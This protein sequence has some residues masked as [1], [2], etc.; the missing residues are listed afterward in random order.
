[1]ARARLLAGAAGLA[2]P[3]HRVGEG[4][5][6][7]IRAHHP[8]TTDLGVYERSPVSA[9]S[10]SEESKGLRRFRA[11][12]TVGLVGGI[13]GLVIPVAANLLA[14]LDPTTGL[15]T[16]SLLGEITALLVVAGTILLAISFIFY[17]YGF[18]ALREFDRWFLAASVLCNIG[19]L[20][21]VLI[22]ISVALAVLSGPDLVQCIQGAPSH[23]L[24]CLDA[25]QPFAGPAVVAG[26]WLA[27]VGGLGIVVGLALGARRYEDMRLVGGAATYGVLL[28][29]LIDP[30]VALLFPI[31]GWQYP[32]LTIP[33]LALIAPIYVYAGSHRSLG[34]PIPGA[35]MPLR[36]A[37]AS[38]REVGSAP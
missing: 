4:T 5:G 35:T 12:A 22:V 17:R 20:G 31:G 13:T 25:V 23:T 19:S 37:R 21:L 6:P 36:D 29:V 8:T 10:T 38:P 7:E 16:G 14:H 26:F 2:G 33:V 18:S 3:H 1:M 11:G 28:L 15:P 27:W 34:R 30:F 24:T 9:N 32:L